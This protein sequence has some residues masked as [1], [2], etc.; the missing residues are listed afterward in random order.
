MPP[1]GASG[2]AASRARARVMSQDFP[3]ERS[4]VSVDGKFFRVGGKK[5]HPKG[6]AYGPFA[7]GVDGHPFPTRERLVADLGMIRDLG[8]NL[9]RVYTVP[10]PWV[11]DLLH[12]HGIKALVDVPWNKH[13]CFL[14]SKAT[15]VDA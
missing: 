11:L 9:V 3:T 4:R 14:D 10:P 6:V 15:R 12:E 13:L 5:F 8:A 2:M 7:R 1:A